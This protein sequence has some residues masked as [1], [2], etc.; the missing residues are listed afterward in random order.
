M[1]PK[2]AFFHTDLIRKEFDRYNVSY[3]VITQIPP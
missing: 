2:A 3:E 1:S